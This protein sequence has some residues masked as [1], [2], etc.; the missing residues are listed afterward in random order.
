MSN[1]NKMNVLIV[2]LRLTPYAQQIDCGLESL[3]SIVG[4][5]IEAIYPFED[6]V[7]LICNAEGKSNGMPYNRALKYGDGTIADVICGTFIVAGLTEESFGS[8][9]EDQIKKYCE[10]FENVEVF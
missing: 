9:S 7:A 10:A 5:D 8:L 2:K 4:G 6:N 3:Q 1:K